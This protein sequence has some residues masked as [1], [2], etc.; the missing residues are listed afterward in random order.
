[1]GTPSTADLCDRL[2]DAVQLCSGR[3]QRYGGRQAVLA[4]AAPLRVF[5][6]AG[7]IRQQLASAGE[8]RILVVDAGA[9][10]RVAVLG[11]R[12]A[13]LGLE[14]G[15]VGVL[16]HGAVRDVD[17]LRT[18]DF[19]VFALGAVPMRGGREGFGEAGTALQI[20]GATVNAGDWIAMDGDGVVRLPADIAVG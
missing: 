4:R 5:E 10:L 11:D 18:I 17:L 9:S 1:M 19:A 14:N 15:W 3:W 8:G 2:G 12:M 6:D 13:R 20:S 7:A 16:V